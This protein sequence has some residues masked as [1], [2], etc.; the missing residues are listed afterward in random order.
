M[1]ETNLLGAMTATEVF[2]DQLRDGG[3]DLV[4]ISSVAGRTA[5]PGRRDPD[6]AHQAAALIPAQCIGCT[7]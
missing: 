4:N 1:I 2:L 5:K 7:A 3:G 6:P